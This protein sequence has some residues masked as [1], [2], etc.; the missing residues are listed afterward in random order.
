MRGAGLRR[1]PVL[2][3]GQLC[4]LTVAAG[5]GAAR[6][7]RA[8]RSAGIACGRVEA[9]ARAERP[10]RLGDGRLTAR[11]RGHGWRTAG[12][13]GRAFWL[14]PADA[15]RAGRL[16]EAGADRP[17]RGRPRWKLGLP[18]AHGR[19]HRGLRQRRRRLEQRRE[20][21]GR[22]GGRPDRRGQAAGR[23][24][25][26]ALRGRQLPRLPARHRRRRRA[27]DADHRG[28]A[29]AARRN[30]RRSLGPHDGGDYRQYDRRAPT[31]RQGLRLH[32]GR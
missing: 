12:T 7:G 2:M 22:L 24:H 19:Q 13:L 3:S 17:A 4:A 25:P 16:R 32:H 20:Q 27:V 1:D 11:I 8:R 31:Q 21:A 10:G 30:P 14:Q 6:A 29:A 23:L 28:R 26:S 5:A 9:A 15:D 18:G